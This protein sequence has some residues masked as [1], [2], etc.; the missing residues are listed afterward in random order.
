VEAGGVNCTVTAMVVGLPSTSVKG[1]SVYGMIG[2]I[3]S[4]APGFADVP[5]IEK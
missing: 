4:D 3:A 1:I 5:L 2:W